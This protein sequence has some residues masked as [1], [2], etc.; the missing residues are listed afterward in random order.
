[1]PI[2][3]PSRADESTWLAGLKKR[4]PEEEVEPGSGITVAEMLDYRLRGE[5]P[6]GATYRDD[7]EYAHPTTGPPLKM[8]GYVRA[9]PGDVRPGVILLHGGGWIGGHPFRYMRHANQL[10]ALGF[11]ALTIQ[12]RLSGEARWPAAI[13]DVKS[14]IRWMR[15]HASELGLDRTRLAVIGSSAGG[16][17]AA[18]SALT[19]GH[20]ETE[21]NHEMPS[22]VSC[23]VLSYPMTDMHCPGAHPWTNNLVE[24]FLGDLSEEKIREAS[25][26][27]YVHAGAPPFL[28]FTGELDLTTPAPMIR[29]FHEALDGCGVTNH[30]H[31][32]PGERHAFDQT[33][34]YWPETFALTVD[35]LER[36]LV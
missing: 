29:K 4:P 21:A 22:A 16:H 27:T 3:T 20:F 24:D 11:V 31:V 19:P 7:I 33:Q 5:T 34:R 6:E 26:I 30:L 25:P 36:H 14:A 8:F 2:T 12:Y 23:A 18:L 9:D 10:A 13:E 1:M 15:A 32:Y 28:T 17:L 35:F